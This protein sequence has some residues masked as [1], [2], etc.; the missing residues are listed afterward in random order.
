[1]VFDFFKSDARPVGHIQR[2]DRHVN[3]VNHLLHRDPG[4]FKHIAGVRSSGEPRLPET[5][6]LCKPWIASFISSWLSGLWK[7]I[8]LDLTF[9]FWARSR[10]DRIRMQDDT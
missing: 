7:F 8:R 3:N 6:A 1:M 9:F 10:C 2:G 5:A 4:L